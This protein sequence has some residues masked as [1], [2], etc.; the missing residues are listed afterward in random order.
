MTVADH[1]SEG[2][3]V[4]PNTDLIQWTQGADDLVQ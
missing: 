3:K 1:R 2:V 4:G